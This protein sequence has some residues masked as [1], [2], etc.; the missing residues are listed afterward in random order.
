[1]KDTWSG[2]VT[3]WF[4]PEAIPEIEVKLVQNV[5]FPSKI[6]PS[7]LTALVIPLLLL[8]KR[9]FGV[10]TTGADVPKDDVIEMDTNKEELLL[11]MKYLNRLS[12]YLFVVARYKK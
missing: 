12:D 5:V 10:E 9:F 2:K 7:I 11:S 6:L 3:V 1:M 8:G 4:E